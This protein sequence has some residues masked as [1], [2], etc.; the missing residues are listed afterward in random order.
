LGMIGTFAVH[1][2]ARVEVNSL[3]NGRK[4]AGAGAGMEEE[5]RVRG[6]SGDIAGGGGGAKIVGVVARGAAGVVMELG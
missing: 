3:K 6:G 5:S 2:D 4:G 1:R